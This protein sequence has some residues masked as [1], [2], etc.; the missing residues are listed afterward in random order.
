MT[1]GA[2][3]P[4]RWHSPAYE[5]LGMAV[6]DGRTPFCDGRDEWLSEDADERAEAAEACHHCPVLTA[7]A[8]AARE[9]R[10]TFG[11]WAGRDLTSTKWGAPHA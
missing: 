8:D 1:A 6:G 11:V 5:R 2:G 7:C 4:R 9:L 10:P 3:G